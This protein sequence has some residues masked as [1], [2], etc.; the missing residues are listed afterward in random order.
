MIK[1]EKYSGTNKL[2]PHLFEH[3]KYVIH[4][5]NLKFIHNLGVQIDKIHRVISFKQEPWLKKYI[6][7]N[8]N[9]RKEAQNEFEKDFFKLMNNAV[10]GKTMENVQNR[11]D[12][13]LTTDDKYAIKYFSKL[14]F[15]DSRFIDGLYLIEMFKREVVY[16]KPIY[17][18]TGIL[19]LSK[20]CMMG[21]HYNT[22]HESFGT[23]YN[24]IYSDTS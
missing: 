9:K 18:G 21:F 24:L 2:I 1:K 11:I 12:L 8:T 6:D 7:F 3:K 5:R 22:I 13:K 14:H 20:L 23:D 19:D 10:F 16:N 17:V 4:Y 15:K